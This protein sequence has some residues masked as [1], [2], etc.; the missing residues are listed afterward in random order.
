MIHGVRFWPEHRHSIDAAFQA[1]YRVD[2]IMKALAELNNK[3]LET[4]K[5]VS[6]TIL[7][8]TLEG[9]R[10]GG[11]MASIGEDLHVASLIPPII[12]IF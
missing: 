2:D 11:N 5:K 8:V 6:P 10:R 3:A 9:F 1:S 4:M 7:K 12:W